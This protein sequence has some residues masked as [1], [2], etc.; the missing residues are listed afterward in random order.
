YV[1]RVNEVSAYERSFWISRSTVAATAFLLNLVMSIVLAR[2]TL[3][4][5]SF[6]SLMLIFNTVT[7]AFQAIIILDVIVSHTGLDEQRVLIIRIV[8]NCFELISWYF[9]STLV[10]LIGLNRLAILT[11]GPISSF[12][13]GRYEYRYHSFSEFGIIFFFLLVCYRIIVFQIVD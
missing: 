10:F 11:T 12:F 6:Y 7:V 2:S 3:L 8:V 1:L 5:K 13:A 4:K 9:T